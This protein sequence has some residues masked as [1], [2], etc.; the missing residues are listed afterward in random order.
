MGRSS[1]PVREEHL[2]LQAFGAL[3][4]IEDVP[5]FLCIG[6]TVSREEAKRAAQILLADLDRFFGEL[7]AC[8]VL[9]RHLQHEVDRAA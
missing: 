2:V 8:S 1:L 6:P 9:L 4:S 7:F 5:D 3:S